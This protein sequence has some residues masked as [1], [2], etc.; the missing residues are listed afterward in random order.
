MVVELF[1]YQR[2]MRGRIEGALLTHQAVMAQMPTG[3]R[4]LS[5]AA[6]FGGEGVPGEAASEGCVDSGAPK[7]AGGADKGDT[8]KG[9]REW[10]CC[11]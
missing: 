6:G 4:I 2:E 1:D 5:R 9:S 7:G 11:A 8:G 3:L 10:G